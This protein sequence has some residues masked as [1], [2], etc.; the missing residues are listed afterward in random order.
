MPWRITVTFSSYNYGTMHCFSLAILSRLTRFPTPAVSTYLPFCVDVPLY[1]QP[2]Y[3][4]MS[5][6]QAAFHWLWIRDHIAINHS[7]R[8]WYLHW[9]WPVNVVSHSVDSCGLLCCTLADP[10]C[11]SFSATHH[12]GD[13]GI[14]LAWLMQ[15]RLASRWTCCVVFKPCWMLLPGQAPVFHWL[16]AAERIKFK[17]RRWLTVVCTVHCTCLLK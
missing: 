7:P 6:C 15:W 2:T 8:S 5:L 11:L 3:H 16:C 17:W 12:A 13:P 1:N 4:W 14:N 9:L 10:K